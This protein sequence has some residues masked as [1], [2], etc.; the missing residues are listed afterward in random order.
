MQQLLGS[1]ACGAPAI[2][3]LSDEGIQDLLGA[4]TTLV[5]SCVAIGLVCSPVSGVGADLFARGKRPSSDGD[6]GPSPASRP[7]GSVA[8]GPSTLSAS[9][10]AASYPEFKRM[11]RQYGQ[12]GARELESGRIRF[13]GKLKAAREPGEMAAARRV[14]EW[15]PSTGLTRTWYETLDAAGRVRSVRP[16]SVEPSRH[17]V[18]DASGNFVGVR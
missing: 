5:A 12:A 9:A 3:N 11:L 4:R 7:P 18:F 14:R 13:Y 2:R 16:M 17:Y 1:L 15:D 6:Q 10:S 8:G